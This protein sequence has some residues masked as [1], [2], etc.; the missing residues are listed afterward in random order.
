MSPLAVR[1]GAGVLALL[2]LL[3]LRRKRWAYLAFVVLGLLSFPAQTHFGVHVPRCQQ[4]I[5]TMRLVGLSLHQSA[6]IALFA[7]V[8]RMSWVQF[9]KTEE[10]ALLALLADVPVGALVEVAVVI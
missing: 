10:R 6:Y 7:G 9:R 3:A 8:Y 1:V 4:L 5:P 2:A